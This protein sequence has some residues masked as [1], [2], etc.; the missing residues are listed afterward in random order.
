MMY[1]TSSNSDVDRGR[2]GSCNREDPVLDLEG[3][4]ACSSL[5][6][7]ESISYSRSRILYDIASDE[8]IN[9]ILFLVDSRSTEDETIAENVVHR[10]R[11]GFNGVQI[12]TEF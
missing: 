1:I 11:I 3:W 9:L 6:S 7:N 12:I 2:R 4:R 10:K 5:S 8:G